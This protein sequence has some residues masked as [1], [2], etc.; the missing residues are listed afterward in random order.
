MLQ[1]DKSRRS[2]CDEMLFECGG[3]SGEESCELALCVKRLQVRV[4]ADELALDIDLC[5]DK[6]VVSGRCWFRLDDR[7]SMGGRHARR[8]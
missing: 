7:W 6:R 5:N 2:S 3:R 8:E 1:C 4:A